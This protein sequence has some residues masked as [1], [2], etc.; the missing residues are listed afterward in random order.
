[1]KVNTI[2]NFAKRL[3]MVLAV[4][5]VAVNAWGADELYATITFLDNGTATDGS[6]AFTNKT[7]PADVLSP[8]SSVSGFSA[9]AYVYQ[10]QDEY[11]WKFGSSSYNGDITLTLAS[12]I[13]NVKKIVVNAK[14]YSSTKATTI[15]C[16]SK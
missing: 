2:H 11:G 16:N 7:N 9:A 13:S 15:N 3:V 10:A 4:G 6:S 8:S 14:K 12:T 1:M 5:L